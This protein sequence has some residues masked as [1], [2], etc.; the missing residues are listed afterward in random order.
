MYLVGIHDA[1]LVKAKLYIYQEGIAREFPTEI[2]S[3][4]NDYVLNKKNSIFLV[5]TA[6]NKVKITLL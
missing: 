4:L 6:V 1:K 2:C 3:F 5:T